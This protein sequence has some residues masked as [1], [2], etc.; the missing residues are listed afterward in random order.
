MSLIKCPACEKEISPNAP[1]CP[2]CGEPLKTKRGFG[3]II[4][5]LFSLAFVLVLVAGNFHVLTGKDVGLS[6]V[7]RE[8]FGYSEIFVD[9]DTITGMPW[10]AAKA[11]YP[12]GC[13]LLQRKGIIESDEQMAQRLRDA[14]QQRMEEAQ[15]RV[16]E[17]LQK[18]RQ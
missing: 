3:V 11:R 12:L 13:R 14:A 6:L 16:Q 8:S 18:Y 9:A 5:L 17:V 1:T 4:F 15:K 10:I 2:H 7:L